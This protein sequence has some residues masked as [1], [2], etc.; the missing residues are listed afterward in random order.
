MNKK[1]QEDMIRFIRTMAD[2]GNWKLYKIGYLG[3]EYLWAKE[4]YDPPF[5][6]QELLDEIE[7]A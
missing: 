1:L 4:S 5:V 2:K 3:N 7:D 6:A